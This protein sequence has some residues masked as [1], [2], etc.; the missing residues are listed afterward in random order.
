MSD[1]VRE[2]RDAKAAS[3]EIELRQELDALRE[4]VATLRAVPS[5]PAPSSHHAELL[6]AVVLIN[7]VWSEWANRFVDDFLGVARVEGE[8]TAIQLAPCALLLPLAALAYFDATQNASKRFL[9]CVSDATMNYV[10]RVAGGYGIVQVLAQD[11]GLKS[12][13]NQRN[14]VQH[15]AVQFLLLW[16]GAFSLTTHRSEGMISVLLYFALKYNVSGGTSDVCF[17]AV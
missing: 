5:R 9:R 3:I 4:E 14:I 1:L 2:S 16:G 11:L 17:E 8:T 15:P 7:L 13:I 12:G 10:L 6:L